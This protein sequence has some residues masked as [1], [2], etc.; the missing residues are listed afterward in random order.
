MRH[1][2]RV[3]YDRLIFRKDGKGFNVQLTALPVN[4]KLVTRIHEPKQDT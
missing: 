4:G 3:P 2:C 1:R